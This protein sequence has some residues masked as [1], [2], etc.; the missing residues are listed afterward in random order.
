ME[1]WEGVAS[2]TPNES[3]GE[4]DLVRFMEEMELCAAAN[5]NLGT[6]P[7]GYETTLPPFPPMFY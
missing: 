7:R 3:K 4:E 6:C 2:E 5:M 1:Y